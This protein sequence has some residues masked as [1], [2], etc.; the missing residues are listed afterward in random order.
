[1]SDLTKIKDTDKYVHVLSEFS[2]LP[3]RWLSSKEQGP[4]S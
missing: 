1:M 2:C 3:K 4:V